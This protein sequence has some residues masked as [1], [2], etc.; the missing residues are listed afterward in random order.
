MNNVNDPNASFDMSIFVGKTVGDNYLLDKYLAEG[1]FG[2]VYKSQ[3]RFLGEN[4]RRVAVKISKTIDVDIT[5]AKDIF[6]DA[7]LLAHAMD[8]MSDA[9]AR[10]HLV[11]IYEMGILEDFSHR[12]FVVMEF[13]QGTNLADQFHA[14]KKVPAN[15]LL[16]WGRQICKAVAGLHTLVPPVL[17]RDLKPDNILLGI[18]RSVRVVD[19]GLAAKMMSHGF[20]PGV[21][22]TTAYMAPE[23]MKGESFPASDVY[24][25]GIILYEGLTGEHPFKDLVPP[26]SQPDGLYSDWLYNRK[27]EVRPSPPSELNNMVSQRLDEVV[28]R[29]LE[30]NPARRFPTAMELMSAL[31]TE[32]NDDLPGD[33][34]LKEGQ[35]LM[36]QNDLQ[37]AHRCFEEGLSIAS[38]SK[39]IR[40]ALL[41]EN[42]RALRKLGDHGPAAESLVKAWKLAE[43][44]AILRTRKERADLLQEI[45]DECRLSNNNF[46]ANN[47]ER[48]RKKELKKQK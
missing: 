43:D 40:F 28:L 21:A 9:E 46:Q 23:T 18:D 39:E 41:L 42:A 44:T 48:L 27:S 5:T 45:V 31:K 38:N 16:Q 35:L 12:M 32:K 34:A 15:L 19:F 4:I 6:A 14:Y 20:V 37:E 7:F 25:I 10:S 36:S 24:S 47:F 11:H 1:N 13:I 8:E 29:C 3:Q 2:A 33:Q 17:H 26:V 30:F 22:G